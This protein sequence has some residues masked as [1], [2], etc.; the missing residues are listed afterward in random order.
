VQKRENFERQSLDKIFTVENKVKN[1]QQKS[2]KSRE[3]ET[4]GGTDSVF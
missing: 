4:L 1:Y 2:G 3:R